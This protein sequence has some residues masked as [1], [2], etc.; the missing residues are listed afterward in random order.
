MAG[1]FAG[2]V[3]VAAVVFPNGAMREQNVTLLSEINDS[4]LLSPQ[5][6]EVLSEFIRNTAMRYAIACV[7]VTVINRV[8]IG[9]ATEK[10]FRN[11]LQKLFVA[12]DHTSA[13]L[14]IDGFHIKYVRNFG[15]K[16]QK[17]I[18]DEDK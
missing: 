5:K 11:V 6:R 10:A 4:K 12:I 3:T 14:L 1:A 16:K 7:P 2:P 13:F 15:L 18:L 8:G 9:K 17:A